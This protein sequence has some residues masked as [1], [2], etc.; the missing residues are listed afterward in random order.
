MSILSVYRNKFNKFNNIVAQLIDSI[1]H[2]TLKLLKLYFYLK[3]TSDLPS[4]RRVK[5][6]V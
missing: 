3:Q 2:M 5:H 6:R 1:L 4:K